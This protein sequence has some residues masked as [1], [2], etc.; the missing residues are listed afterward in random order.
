MKGLLLALALV[1]GVLLAQGYAPAKASHGTPVLVN[2]QPG[3]LPIDTSGHVHVKCDSGCSGAG[4]GNPTAGYQDSLGL[5]KEIRKLDSLLLVDS[6]TTLHHVA[7]LDSINALR[8]VDTVSVVS[9]VNGTVAVTKS[10]VWGDSIYSW[11]GST[12]PTVG[13]KTS[14]NSIPVVVAS[15]DSLA[16]SVNIKNSAVIATTGGPSDSTQLRTGTKKIGAV[17]DSLYSWMGSTAPTVGSK[18]SANSIPVVVASDDSLAASVNVKTFPALVAGGAKIGNVGDSL[19]YPLQ[20]GRVKTAD[21][22]MSPALGQAAMAASL[23]VTV[24]NNQ[25]SLTVGA[26]GDTGVSNYCKLQAL[27][28]VCTIAVS[29]R[30]YIGVEVDSANRVGSMSLAVEQNSDS[31]LAS[32]THWYQTIFWN[33]D[34]W[35][36][37]DTIPSADS[38]FGGGYGRSFNIPSNS[39]NT[40]WRV[41]V[42]NYISGFVF[43]RIKATPVVTTPQLLTCVS[44]DRIAEG[45][46]GSGGVMFGNNS[47]TAT[48]LPC[49]VGGIQDST[50]AGFAFRMADNINSVGMSSMD[51]L[52]RPLIQ[53]RSD[54]ATLGVLNAKAIMRLDGVQGGAAV[55]ISTSNLVG[56]IVARVSSDSVTWTNTTLLNEVTLAAAHSVVNP[57]APSNYTFNLGSSARFVEI[58]DTA[59]TSGSVFITLLGTSLVP[60]FNATSYANAATTP[61]IGSKVGGTFDGVKTGVDFKMAVTTPPPTDTGTVVIIHPNSAGQPQTTDSCVSQQ[62]SFGAA[63]SATIPAHAGLRDY[64]YRILVQAADTAAITGGSS[65]F[66][67][68][69][70]TNAY[71]GPWVVGAAIALGQTLTIANESPMI[72]Y[73]TTAQNT[74][75]KLRVN[76]PGATARITVLKAC[77]QLRP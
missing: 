71:T 50:N 49:T 35:V 39:V 25:S 9:K 31:G 69:T 33:G 23:P 72:P 37:A 76:S 61:Y 56:T 27:N 40:Y 18:T 54:T 42:R 6:M 77:Y 22:L 36:G 52:V 53:D 11:F 29:G 20:N 48:L 30:A 73:V 26:F 63:D 2:G 67:S 75:T 51:M 47:N 41:R 34:A 55:W 68:L 70:V 32:G 17:G 45:G 13:S 60:G 8:H 57:A 5:V 62:G 19:Y 12:A 64:I 16:A 10:G 14:A 24:A 3:S 44:I 4:G 65:V 58:T 15:D 43:I 7:L 74:A 59:Y 66:D 46:P 1:P 38:G 28:A 21:S